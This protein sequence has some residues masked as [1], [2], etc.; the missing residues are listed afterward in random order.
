MP[1]ERAHR[2]KLRKASLKRRGSACDRCV[3]K[4]A[5]GLPRQPEVDVPPNGCKLERKR[6]AYR[7][8]LYPVS[9]VYG[10]SVE[11][12]C[13]TPSLREA[14][15]VSTSCL[16]DVCVTPRPN[17]LVKHSEDDRISYQDD[18]PIA[19]S[20]VQTPE[21]L[22]CDQRD[23]SERKVA[24]VDQ[25]N[26][27]YYSNM[28]VQPKH[29]PLLQ[30]FEIYLL[31]NSLKTG[32][33][34]AQVDTGSQV[35]LVKERSLIKG[36]DI[37]RHV[38]QIRGITVDYLETKGQIELRIGETSSHKFLVVNSLPM[39]CE[40]LLGQDWLEKFGYQFQIP[41]LGI[42]LPACSETL[43]RIPTTAQGNRL[44]E[45]QELQDNIFC[46]SSVVECKDF[47][48]ICSIINLN[49][50]DETLKNFQ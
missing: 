35:S 40:I 20:C 41:S 43:V 19:N 6:Y 21:T 24:A 23:H 13:V 27:E 46:A 18:I 17:V 49:S 28:F 22:L 42:N 31:C 9:T 37:T 12:V 11:E 29:G 45:A 15:P 3:G 39:N 1:Q 14:P 4:Q 34:N 36:S 16:M 33:G 7:G 8:I 32:L 44:V 25:N 2:K 30:P 26:Q 47:S 50:T 38:L 5:S 10:D 48:F